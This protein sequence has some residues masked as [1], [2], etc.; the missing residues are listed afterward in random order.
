MFR[1]WARVDHSVVAPASWTEGSKSIGLETKAMSDSLQMRWRLLSY[2][3]NLQANLVRP[4]RSVFAS[5]RLSPIL[6]H[7]GTSNTC[8]FCYH[9]LL[10]SC[11]EHR[12]ACC[13]SP[14]HHGCSRHTMDPGHSCFS[15]YSFS[16]RLLLFWQECFTRKLSSL[17]GIFG[18]L[19][20]GTYKYLSVPS[21][22]V[23]RTPIGMLTPPTPHNMSI[24][25]D[26]LV[27]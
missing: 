9:I 16:C 3:R 18:E 12:V 8:F 15:R 2:D 7:A 14:R 6:L 27:W 19:T 25:K 17:F 10:V 24:N 13:G 11:T 5:A 23:S 22:T 20:G 21:L 26:W 1:G 4:D